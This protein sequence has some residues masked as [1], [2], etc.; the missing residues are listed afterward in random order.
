MLTESDEDEQDFKDE[1]R[2]LESVNSSIDMPSFRPPQSIE[3][4]YGL[5][6]Q[7]KPKLSTSRFKKKVD[8][9]AR[10]ESNA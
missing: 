1:T 5:D 4:T 8:S 3:E 10:I 7:I 9:S 2:H 6:Q